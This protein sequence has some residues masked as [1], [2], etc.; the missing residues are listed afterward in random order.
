MKE[1]R[2]FVP[3]EEELRNNLQLYKE[4]LLLCVSLLTNSQQKAPRSSNYED[5][6]LSLDEELRTKFAVS[7]KLELGVHKVTAEEV[8]AEF[9]PRSWLRDTRNPSEIRKTKPFSS[10]LE[11]IDGD[12][13][14]GFFP[15]HGFA[16]GD[17]LGHKTRL[18][19][20]W[21]LVMGWE[22]IYYIPVANLI[23]IE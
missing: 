7:E 22:K 23:D 14:N 17:E 11:H 10:G 12:E 3:S 15:L 19:T 9:I 2:P 6:I 5:R 4:L 16:R 13:I 8:V 20:N 21:Y 1:P 18:G